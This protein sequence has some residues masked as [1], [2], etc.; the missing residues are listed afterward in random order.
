MRLSIEHRGDKTVLQALD[1]DRVV[2]SAHG[3]DAQEAAGWLMQQ[4]ERH[5]TQTRDLL[6]DAGLDPDKRPKPGLPRIGPS[7]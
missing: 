6:V 3:V 5:V 1:N 2:A 4:V 7:W